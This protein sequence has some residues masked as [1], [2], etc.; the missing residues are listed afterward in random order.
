MSLREIAAGKVTFE[1]IKKLPDNL[2]KI[3][4]E[5]GSV[6]DTSTLVS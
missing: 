5:S 4:N 6:V 2:G 3:E 1:N